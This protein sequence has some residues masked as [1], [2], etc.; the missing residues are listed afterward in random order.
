MK[1]N[2]TILQ[3]HNLERMEDFYC[4]TLGF[5]LLK[6][7]S[8]F[9]EIEVGASKLSFE[10][11]SPYQ[12]KQYHFAFNIPNNLFE[13]AKSW[14][15]T[16]TSLLTHRGEDEIFFESINA[17]SV[18]FYD[19][20]ENIVELIARHTL[21][22]SRIVETFSSKAIID[23]GEMNLT[24]DNVLGVGQTLNEIGIP[25]RHNA[26]LNESSLN[27][28]GENEDGTHIL[29]GPSGRN[30]F[31]STKEAKVSPIVIEVNEQLRLKVDTKG[32]FN[33]EMI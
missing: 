4:R 20:E 14:V 23:I 2:K 13:K 28:I 19:P 18:Y 21:N 12:Q 30:W 3:V 25:V 26:A 17:H 32:N 24:T 27:F 9:F 29:L 15:Q 16:H 31:F 8:N 5:K 11:A 1:I 7:S 10:L 33:Y 6:K 22:L